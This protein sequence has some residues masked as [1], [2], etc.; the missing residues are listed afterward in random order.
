M[1]PFLWTLFNVATRKFKITSGARTWEFHNSTGQPGLGCSRKI[2]TLVR[3][4][5]TFGHTSPHPLVHP[6]MRCHKM[7]GVGKGAIVVW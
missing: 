3:G 6:G 2:I 4:L 1:H 5:Q 7:E